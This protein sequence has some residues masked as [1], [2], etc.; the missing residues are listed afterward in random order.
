MSKCPQF[1]LLNPRT[2]ADGVP[3]DQLK[4]LR[5]SCP[6]SKQ[7]DTDNDMDFWAITRREDLD[8][9]SKNPQLFSSQERLCLIEEMD[10]EMLEIQRTQIVHMDPPDHIKHRRIVR[11]AFTAKA[12]DALEPFIRERIGEVLDRVLAKG[13]CEFVSEVAAEVPLLVVCELMGIPPEERDVF[14]GHVNVML[15]GLDPTT[16]ISE[17]EQT[18]SMMAIFE[19][20]NKLAAQHKE[21]PRDDL[22]AK[23]MDGEVDGE[24][25]NEMEFC[26]FFLL[27]IVGGIETTRTSTSQGMR[28]LM[29]HPDQYRWLQQ[30]PEAVS[31]AVEEILRFNPAFMHMRRTAMEDV[32]VNGMQIKKGDKVV[33]MYDAVN[34]DEAVFGDSSEEFNVRRI[35]D[36]P[37]LKNE[38]RTFGVGQ[39]FCLGSHLARKEMNIVFEEIVKRIHNPQFAG[40]P[41][42]LQSN[43]ISGIR[44]MNI[45]FDKSA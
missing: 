5:N 35:E 38:H 16:G 31:G 11:N 36:M 22:I 12:V 6:V 32:E 17:D 4:E 30:H 29:E 2:Y 25:L 18:A 33:L 19:Q 34:H 43:F 8:Y 3:F 1:D 42:N 39:H 14:G 45:T 9:I 26:T 20:A 37:E 27:L 41:R 44:E 40:C 13:E 7:R 10:G 24:G 23:L 15:E 21:N 28:L